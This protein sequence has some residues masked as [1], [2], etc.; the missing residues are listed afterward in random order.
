MCIVLDLI[1]KLYQIWYVINFVHLLIFMKSVKSSFFYKKC[2]VLYFYRVRVWIETGFNIIIKVFWCTKA[3][4]TFNSI[5]NS[6]NTYKSY[7]LNID[8]FISC[9][10]LSFLWNNIV[11]LSFLVQYANM[12]LKAFIHDEKAFLDFLVFFSFSVKRWKVEE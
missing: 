1:S 9:Y 11:L 2:T 8:Y 6:N 5:I 3:L 4:A 10:Y 12:H 7:W